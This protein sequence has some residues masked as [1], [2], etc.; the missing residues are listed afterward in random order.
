MMCEQVGHCP[1]F[2]DK[3]PMEQGIGAIFKKKYCLGHQEI[4]ARYQ[5]LLALGGNA[6]PDTLYPN[7]HNVA[8]KLIEEATQKPEK[9]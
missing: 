9:R 4:C 2:N 3:I 7:M 8:K 6:V 1:F 5:I